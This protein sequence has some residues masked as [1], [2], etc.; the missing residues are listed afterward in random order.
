M[1]EGMKTLIIY[2]IKQSEQAIK[3]ADILLD[4]NGSPRSVVNR[5][6]YGMFYSCLALLVTLGKGSSKHSGVI[7]LFDA[8]FVKKG[9]FHKEMSRALHQAFDLRQMSDYR[10]LIEVDID[11]AKEL[12]Q[13]AKKFIDEVKEYILKEIN[14]SI[15][16]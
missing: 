3:D 5:A 12:L 14:E 11:D 8:E 2:R 9:I 4:M 15:K 6:Y 7:G 10:E 16:E 1:N 13:G